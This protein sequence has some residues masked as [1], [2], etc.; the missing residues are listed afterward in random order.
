LPNGTYHEQ[1]QRA[2]QATIFRQ[3]E[4]LKLAPVQPM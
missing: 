2:C 1:G 3:M 4:S